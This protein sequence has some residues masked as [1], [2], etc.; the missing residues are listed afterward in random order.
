MTKIIKKI[1]NLGLII[2]IFC[3]LFAPPFIKSFN[4]IFIV[5]GYSIIMII[6][7]YRTRMKKTLNT[8]YFKNIFTILFLYFF[9]YILSVLINCLID[10]EQYLDNY[11]INFYTLML[12]FPI[13]ITCSLYL[14]FRCDEL[15]ISFDDVIRLF[16]MAGLI[17]TIIA[18]L[19]L[20]FPALKKI[21][22]T[23][24]YTATG[25]KLLNT[26]WITERRFFGFANSMLDSFGFGT[27]ILAT[28]PIFYAA[29]TGK[30]IY[31]LF[32]PILL[33]VPMLNS[34]SGLVMF[35]IGLGV[36][37]IYLG[38]KKT[39]KFGAYCKYFIIILLLLSL[40][41]Y[42]VNVYSPNTITWII[43]DIK[44]FILSDNTTG[45]ATQLFSNEFWQLPSTRGLLIGT[46][47]NISGY[48]D[49]S[50]QGIEHSDVGY[51]NEL[52]K[53]GIIGSILLYY[54]IY[55]IIKIALINTKNNYYKA[56]F[57]TFAIASF[58]FLIKATIFS[59]NPGI[60]IIY[61][62]SLMTIYIDN[63]HKNP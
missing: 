23:I 33:I 53:A 13:T 62:L 16:I 17:Q 18:I 25:D 47:H 12:T 11:I 2:F 48:S 58:T 32:S 8:K 15:N 9:V 43:Q 28:L 24:M 29:K 41:I 63:K 59:Y 19:T 55:Y 45:T 60:V 14:I 61:T 52:W 30:K 27:G 49:Y 1:N 38:A 35:I 44:S 20:L 31:Y 40:G 26:P 6:L 54:S 22:I 10:G 3:F 57:I 7:K 56:M 5:F 37:F 42:I 21:T 51:V 39:I 4:F 34:R 46:G 50:V 36:Y